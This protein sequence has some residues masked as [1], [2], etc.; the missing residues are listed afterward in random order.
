MNSIFKVFFYLLLFLIVG[1]FFGYM[2]F[3]ILSFSRTVEVPNLYG[4][5]LVESNKILSDRGLYLKIEG[6]DF[7]STIPPGN[8]IKQDIP[9][10]E[11]IKEKRSIK[12]IISKGPKIRAVPLLLNETIYNAD[13]ILL[14]KGLKIGRVIMVHS[15]S[16]EKD[17]VIAQK[18]GPNEQIEDQI[19]LIVSLGPY[20]R[21]YICPDFK[22]MSIEQAEEIL[23]RL[24][25][26]Y[27]KKG[28]TGFVQLQSPP[29]GS[30]IKK[31]DIISLE[32]Y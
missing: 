30:L 27:I 31:G 16:V 32:V 20:D 24:N 7:S 11:K 23:K 13:S 12:V 26:K 6:E 9:P 8:I 29:P 15:D 22:G 28:T 5:S 1:I 3:K 21:E 17:K 10:G 19:T 4:K 25:I 2:T 14:Q 18:P